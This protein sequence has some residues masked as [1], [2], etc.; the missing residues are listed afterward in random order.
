MV[1]QHYSRGYICKCNVLCNLMRNN[2]TCL[3]P[4]LSDT[5]KSNGNQIAL[6]VMYH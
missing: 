4:F 6:K 3:L 2:Y 1:K 5:F